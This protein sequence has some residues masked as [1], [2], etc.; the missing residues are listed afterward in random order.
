MMKPMMMRVLLITN[1]QSGTRAVGCF[2]NA[3]TQDEIRLAISAAVAE[4]VGMSADAL[5]EEFTVVANS[6]YT[7]DFYCDFEV[8]ETT[9]Y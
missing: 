4:E 1:R 6:C 9:V 7:E 3:P 2:M 5:A 8:V